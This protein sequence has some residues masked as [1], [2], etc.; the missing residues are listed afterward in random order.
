MYSKN[1]LQI[2]WISPALH[3]SV[4]FLYSFPLN[5]RPS[6]GFRLYEFRNTACVCA[7][8]GFIGYSVY[9]Q[10]P[11]TQLCM[12]TELDDHFTLTLTLYSLDIQCSPNPHTDVI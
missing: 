10:L 8:E 1:I 5:T 9:W 11:T 6:S 4:T 12:D 2:G 3:V 7:V